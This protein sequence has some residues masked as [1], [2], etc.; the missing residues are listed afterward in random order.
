MLNNKQNKYFF[1][2]SQQQHHMKLVPARH[3]Q[4][5]ME[6]QLKQHCI[7]KKTK[8]VYFHI[9]NETHTHAPKRR[10]IKFTS[11]FLL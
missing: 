8:T 4:M 11:T 9:S 3:L 2:K 10:Q 6:I 1:E 5:N 7:K